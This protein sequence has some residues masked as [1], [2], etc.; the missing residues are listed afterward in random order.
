MKDLQYQ[1]PWFAQTSPIS[2]VLSFFVVELR[3]WLLTNEEYDK[4]LTILAKL[5]GLPADAEFVD[6]EFRSMASQFENRGAGLGNNHSKQIIRDTFMV[7]SDLRRVQLT[8]IVYIL[9]QMSGANAITNY[10]PT[11]FGLIGVTDSDVK[12]YSTGLYTVA[13][14]FCCAAASLFLI[15]LVRR[16]KSLMIGISVQIMSHSYLAGYLNVYQ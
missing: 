14:L 4:S 3:R 13:K 6:T 5:C 10:L 2:I 8:I 1:T 15:D 11:I 16:R 9:A 12:V 7:K